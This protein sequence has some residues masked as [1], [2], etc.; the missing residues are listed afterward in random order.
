MGTQRHVVAV[1]ANVEGVIVGTNSCPVVV[2]AD[3]DGVSVVAVAVRSVFGVGAVVVGTGRHIGPCSSWAAHATGMVVP[4]CGVGALIAIVK[5]VRLFAA[6]VKGAGLGGAIIVAAGS[7]GAEVGIICPS[8]MG[9]R[10]DAVVFGA[11]DRA[12]VWFALDGLPAHVGNPT[13]GV[14]G[15]QLRILLFVILFAIRKSA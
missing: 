15:G 9:M 7:G 5:G 6:V 11:E 14:G 4:P 10:F 2:S 13:C 12:S 8:T 1:G 3:V